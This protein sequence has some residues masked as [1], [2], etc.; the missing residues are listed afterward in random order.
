M[1]EPFREKWT[2]DCGNVTL[3]LGDCLEI[4]PTLC[5]VDC[6]VTDPPYGIAY[7]SGREGAIARRIDGD[8]TT[9][10]RDAIIATHYPKAVFA[11]WRCFPPVKPRGVLIWAKNAGGMGDLSFPWKTDFELIWI[12]GD[13]WIG[14][15]G[16]GI[17]HASTVCSW[18]TGPTARIHPHEKPVDLLEQIVCKA[19]GDTVADP[20]MGSGTTGVAC[21]RLGRKF[22]GIELEPRYYDIAKRRIRDELAKSRFLDP[23]EKKPTQKRLVD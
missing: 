13:G 18:N 4:L 2:S 22:I 7:E 5:K 23:P 14:H 15:R 11:T 19:P 20:T 21:V 10:I 17:L 1:S 3:Y 12:Y 16:S 6:V 9:E 8:K